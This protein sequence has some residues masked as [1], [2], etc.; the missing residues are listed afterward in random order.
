MPGAALH[1]ASEPSRAL[2]QSVSSSLLWSPR[3]VSLPVWHTPVASAATSY[4]RQYADALRWRSNFITCCLLLIAT[5]Q[6]SRSRST[7]SQPKASV[8]ISIL[9]I[10]SSPAL[11]IRSFCLKNIR[12]FM[13][14]FIYFLSL[15]AFLFCSLLFVSIGRESLSRG[16][17]APGWRTSGR[18]ETAYTY[19]RNVCCM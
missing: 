1:S 4:R 10:F 5:A 6:T 15:V 7:A 9:L 2:Q 3:S 8:I 11:L 17:I 16:T 14:I 13:Y 12:I 18:R 19:C